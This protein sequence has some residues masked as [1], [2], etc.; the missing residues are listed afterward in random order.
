ML[1]NRLKKCAELVSGKGI[2][3]D[4]GTDHAYLAAELVISGKCDNVIA[5]DINEG[6]LDAAAKTVKK[7]GVADKVQLVLSDGLDNVPREDISDIIIAGMG[8][9]T[10]ADILKR[11]VGFDSDVQYILQPMTKIDVLRGFLGKY[12]FKILSETA[13]V[14][15]LTFLPFFVFFFLSPL[16]ALPLSPIASSFFSS[17]IGSKIGFTFLS[18][19]FFS[20]FLSSLFSSFLS[21]LISLIHI[22]FS[23]LLLLIFFH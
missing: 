14:S 15:I 7:Y 3:C 18:S 11:A 21:S 5:C 6:P 12:G 2:A 4:V 22:L 17:F 1:D 23:L 19:S 8:G 10:I 13:V 20:S 9:E 16:L